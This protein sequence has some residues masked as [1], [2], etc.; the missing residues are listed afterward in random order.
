MLLLV[1]FVLLLAQPGWAAISCTGTSYPFSTPSDPQGQAHTFPSLTNGIAIVHS[2]VRNGAR[3]VQSTPT[4]GGVSTTR[5]NA[6]TNSTDTVTEV[7][8][9]LNP[10]SGS[11]TVS[12]DWDNV[13]LSYVLTVV[14]CDGVNQASPIGNDNAATGSSTSVS[15]SCTSASGQLVLDFV[16]AENNTALTTGAGQTNL[17]Q[18]VADVTS[19]V[20][21]SSSEPGAASVTMTQTLANSND[22]ATICVALA[23]AVTTSRRPVAPMVFQ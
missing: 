16:S 22:W 4:I 23:E 10:S 6:R 20:G 17:D 7:F 21:G 12:V 9:L 8:Y 19:L 18:D 11:Q 3:V 1:L 13:P 14:T 5:I 2:A 15:V